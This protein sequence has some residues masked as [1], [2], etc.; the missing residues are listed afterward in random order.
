MRSLET[1]CMSLLCYKTQLE[2]SRSR[3]SA[4][5]HTDVRSPNSKAPPP[6]HVVEKSE[7]SSSDS[8]EEIPRPHKHVTKLKKDS[9]NISSSTLVSE[10]PSGRQNSVA[11]GYV[12][13]D[14]SQGCKVETIH[15][16]PGQT[17]PVG[18]TPPS[19]PTSGFKGIEWKAPHYVLQRFVQDILELCDTPTSQLLADSSDSDTGSSGPDA[20]VQIV[21]SY[22]T[23]RSTFVEPLDRFAD[24]RHERSAVFDEAEDPVVFKGISWESSTPGTPQTLDE[25]PCPSPRSRSVRDPI[26]ANTKDVDNV[27]QR[28]PTPPERPPNPARRRL[29]FEESDRAAMSEFNS[30][31]ATLVP[32]ATPSRYI[33][34]NL[35]E[36]SRMISATSNSDT[37]A[38]SNRPSS[39]RSSQ[40]GHP[41]QYPRPAQHP[42]PGRYHGPGHRHQ[43]GQ[44]PHLEQYLQSGQHPPPSQRRHQGQNLGQGQVA[45]PGGNAGAGQHPQVQQQPRAGQYFYQGQH[46]RSGGCPGPGQQRRLGQCHHLIQYFHP[47]QFSRLGQYPP[48]GPRLPSGL[49]RPPVRYLPRGQHLPPDIATDHITEVHDSHTDTQDVTEAID[50][51]CADFIVRNELWISRPEIPEVDTADEGWSRFVRQMAS[52][53]D[54]SSLV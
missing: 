2:S 24:A 31:A 9:A 10:Q 51:L 33:P 11:S 15:S 30:S 50:A 42:R 34:R 14:P 27:I 29:R 38:A 5:G 47:R 6:Q 44:Y 52:G 22:T 13:G 4:Q 41:S 1:T 32:D 48:P 39:T 16:H 25:S 28:P 37:P 19:S 7:A 45:R 43:P 8:N 12:Y 17:T 21:E 40:Y 3:A 23:L 26:R 49:R 18:P 46:P 35:I 20:I 53:M 36:D 54:L